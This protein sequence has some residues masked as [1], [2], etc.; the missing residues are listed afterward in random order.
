MTEEVRRIRLLIRK[1]LTESLHPLEQQELD[2]WMNQSDE[3]RVFFDKLQNPDFIV[4]ELKKFHSAETEEVLQ[5]VVFRTTRIR[6]SR[7]IAVAASMIVLCVFVY[8]YSLYVNKGSVSADTSKPIAKTD[9]P[10]ARQRATLIVQG[11]GSYVLDSVPAGDLV[12]GAHKTKEGALLYDVEGVGE[13][14]RQTLQTPK[15]GYYNL[16]LQDGT[17]VWMNA[18]SA[19]D[20]PSVFNGHQRRVAL[21]G[22]AYFEVSKKELPFVVETPTGDVTVLGTHFNVKSYPSET[23]ATTLLEGMV[24]VATKDKS[25][26][27]TL[28]PGQQARIREGNQEVAV[29]AAD[30]ETAVAWKEGIFAFEN[31]SF[32]EVL[33]EISRWY[34]A[35]VVIENGAKS[36][37]IIHGEFDRTLSLEKLLE[38]I[39]PITKVKLIT[40][41]GKIIVKP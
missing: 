16:T 36:G 6:R 9:V 7:W 13:V 34:G 41:Q 29:R 27:K 2:E 12:G 20:Y 23:M 33:N 19:L 4:G 30:V 31:A 28:Q 38:Q 10:P 21:R 1:S 8:L 15:G 14:T 35:P 3:N 40:E 24:Q 5:P 11:T 26:T 18:A 25:T 39:Q 22:E 32:D 17:R 37:A